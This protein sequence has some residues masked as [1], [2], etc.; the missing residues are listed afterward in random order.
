M[1]T[2]QRQRP[3]CAISSHDLHEAQLTPPLG[4]EPYVSFSQEGASSVSALLVSRS[5]IGLI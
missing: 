3:S 2:M 1:L 5:P 4:R